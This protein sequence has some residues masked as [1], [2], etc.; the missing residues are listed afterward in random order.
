MVVTF[1][2]IKLSSSS[3]TDGF[4]DT[5]PNFHYYLEHAST[6][7]YLALFGF[8]LMAVGAIIGPRKV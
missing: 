2:A 4:D 8:V 3:A 1:V 6:G 7:F 5:T